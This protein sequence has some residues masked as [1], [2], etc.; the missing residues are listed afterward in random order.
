MPLFSTGTLQEQNV[1]TYN[2]KG[3]RRTAFNV[4]SVDTDQKAS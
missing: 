2:V 4:L 3:R 1:E